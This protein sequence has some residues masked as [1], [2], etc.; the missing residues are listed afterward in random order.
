MNK[1]P[2]I[3]ISRVNNNPVNPKGDYVLYWMVA[4]RRVHW[5][6]SLQRS[7]EWALE[8]DKPLIILE[9]LRY[10]YTWACD[11][12]HQFIMDGMRDNVKSLEKSSVTYF[13]F[14]ETPDHSGKGLVKA[15]SQNACVL[16]TDDFP[17]FFLPRMIQAAAKQVPV[18]L[19]KVD[20]NG[21]LPFRAT[22]RVFTVAHSFRRFLHKTLPDYLLE[23][24]LE[25]PL[26]GSKLKTLT[27][28]PKQIVKTWPMA[29]LL[30]LGG[31]DFSSLTIDHNVKSTSSE[32]GEK[33]AN[34]ILQDFIHSKLNQYS[35]DRNHPDLEG[36]SELSPYLHFGHIS[37]HEIFYQII[38]KENWSMDRLFIKPTGGKAGWWG[39]S[40]S[41]EAF[42]DQI[43]IWRE[44]GFNMCG[45]RK[46][47]DQYESLPGWA[48][49]TLRNHIKDTR[50]YLYS[51]KQFEQ[52][53]THDPLWNAAQMELV[54]KGRI[55]NYLRML[56]GKK[57]LEWSPTPK[58]ALDIMIELNNK[59]ALD[60]RDPNSYSGI[61]WVLGRYD[62]AWGPE[63][64][65]FGK[66][67]YMS[68][69]NTARKLKLKNYLEQY[70]SKSDFT[71]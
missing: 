48:L 5:N 34:I 7:V 38:G 15:L 40:E 60:G 64:S 66:V 30:D 22:D 54:K 3:R 55:H 58:A 10:G 46:D 53:R 56:W 67:R 59:Y 16:V 63:R 8:L 31:K 2:P 52:A 37:C 65:V 47:Y 43:I 13:P 35:T 18:C 69:D 62:R 14:V 33:A 9:A 11:R 19:E 61:F 17:D 45:L 24:P 21:I 57:I 23:M 27:N 36:T 12:F 49:K 6:F 42:L 1:V 32:G 25:D 4:F 20:S 39:M 29:D 51:L 68:S 50:P 41:A 71:I 44:L 26:K 28:I 70:S